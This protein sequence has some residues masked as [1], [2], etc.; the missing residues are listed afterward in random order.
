M[1]NLNVYLLCIWTEIGICICK[2]WRRKFFLSSQ[3][4][5]CL[6][7]WIWTYT[8]HWHQR[9]T[10]WHNTLYLGTFL[11]KYY[12]DL[13]IL[14]VN[15]RWTLKEKVRIKETRAIHQKSEWKNWKQNINTREKYK[16]TERQAEEKAIVRTLGSEDLSVCEYSRDPLTRAHTPTCTDT[17][18]RLG[19]LSGGV[20]C[21]IEHKDM[22]EF[23]QNPTLFLCVCACVCKWWNSQ[24]RET[25]GWE[26]CL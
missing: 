17:H 19:L 13:F 12:A 20:L 2:I 22:Y 8:T 18:S 3:I 16:Q 1:L 7:F 23:K 14:W 6:Y 26:L 5:K 11:K 4:V 24:I 15:R 9:L 21:T 10:C 25:L